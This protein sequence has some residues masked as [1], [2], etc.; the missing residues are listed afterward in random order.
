MKLSTPYVYC[1]SARSPNLS[2]HSSRRPRP[3]MLSRTLAVLLS[4]LSLTVA[5]RAQ[6]AV[7][8]GNQFITAH[9]YTDD[10]SGKFGITAGSAHNNTQF[11]FE[12]ITLVTSHVVFRVDQPPQPPRYYCNVPDPFGAGLPRPKV[13]GVGVTF[14]PYDHLD[15]SSDTIA[16]TWDNIYG[17]KVTMRFIPEKSTSIYDDGADMLL[18]FSYER[19]VY[20]Y[21]ELG[22][23][24]MLDTYNSAAS[25]FSGGGFG[26]QTSIVADGG[27]FEVDTPG[28][29][30]ID[31][32]GPIPTFYHVG[33]FLY[34]D[35]FTTIFPLHKLKG[36]TRGGAKL[37]PPDLFVI[38]DWKRLR[39]VSWDPPVAVGGEG[40][41]DCA[42]LLRWEKLVG[43]GTIRTSFGMNNK[44][45]NDMYTCRDNQL[46]VDIRTKRV[47]TQA[48]KNGP[49][50][51]EQFDVEMWIS[52][53]S[54]QFA[55]APQIR[56]D[57]PIVSIPDSTHR[58]TLDP[59]T[60]AIQY[61]Q[62][63]PRVT[64]KLVWRLSVNH[65]SADT[66]AILKFFHKVPF[67]DEKPFLDPC[68]PLV[69]VIG[70]HDPPPDPPK[71]TV[72]PSIERT[73]SGRNE[74]AFW[75]FRTTDRHL[76]FQY[77]SGLDT[78]TV[79]Q[80][81]NDNFELIVAP[82]PFTKCDTSVSV[83]ILAQV[84]DT[85]KAAHLV[86]SVTD[87]RGN[88]AF[89]S[90]T[91]RPRPDPFKPEVTVNALGTKGPPCNA[92]VYEVFA[93]D[94]INQYPDR[95]DHGMGTIEVIGTPINFYPIEINF[96]RGGLPI[97]K[98][99]RGASFRMRVI[100]TLL[101][102]SATVRVADFAGNDTLIT[103]NY[104][105][106]SD[107]AAPRARAIL[108]A[109][110]ESWDVMVSDTLPWDRGLLEVVEVSNLN[111]N[112]VFTPPVIA[113][114]APTA[115]LPTLYVRD[116]SLDA[117]IT[118][119][120]HDL[121]WKRNPVGHATQFTLKFSRIPDT[122][123]PNIIFTPDPL[124]VGSIG[125]VE[126]NDIHFINNVLYK[127]DVG[128]SQINVVAVSPN[129]RVR[130]QTPITFS[131]GAEKVN[132]QVEIIDTL[133]FNILDSIC[134]EAV[135]LAGNTSK[136]CYYYPVVPDIRSP[137]FLGQISAG[138]TEL[139]G[140]ASDDRLYDRGL[141]SISLENP[142]NLEPG[143]SVPN[144][145][146]TPT[147]SVSIA[148]TD[149]KKP[150]AGT[151]VV[152]DLVAD[153]DLTGEAQV[154][155]SLRMPFYLPAVSLGLRFPDQVEGGEPIDVRLVALDSF[156]AIEVGRIEFDA[157]YSGE[158]VYA[159]SDGAGLTVVDD[160]ATGM[161]VS[162]LTESGKLY[163]PGDTLGV[164]HF[165]TQKGTTVRKFRFDVTHG[166]ETVNSGVSKVIS[167]VQ[168]D[169]SAASFLKL[170]TIYCAVAYDSVTMINGECERVLTGEPGALKGARLAVLR[171][172]PQPVSTS[173]EPTVELDVRD[174][175]Y[176]G[177]TGT[178]MSS[179]GELLARF[180]CPKTTGNGIA[181]LTVQLPPTLS[182][183]LYFIRLSGS[184]GE[185]IVRVVVTE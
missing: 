67:E 149:P 119:E 62:L 133:T 1:L 22:I 148:V 144:L 157:R 101:D 153:R 159:G 127:Y 139:S 70:F 169:D 44:G 176:E 56:L 132:F 17:F 29:K 48:Q 150:I 60:P 35:D 75:T 158:A 165:T 39:D 11:L 58:L 107:T 104:C 7:S 43:S 154:V 134:L 118:L 140:T 3:A 138:R 117:Q 8:V 89:D 61:L 109:N 166:S 172:M 142:V 16:V 13:Q 147:T 99:D 179:A 126:I 52:N 135:D 88:V 55:I 45:V 95:G 155:H 91:Y 125:E 151:L 77:D 47:V 72:A 41:K 87:C 80:N 90:A 28:R 25:S 49:Y 174:L 5:A 54:T 94:T 84:I 33:N 53:T 50:D 14:K 143:F 181:H 23:V 162:L 74:T 175:P 171:V 71:D 184:T 93:G 116:N 97:R 170:P 123:A 137:L 59:S 63:A 106:L 82:F 69:T 173:K 167:V 180:E 113:P 183:G 182:S 9:V 10:R 130:P 121:E 51:P 98:F 37:T 131:P 100:D 164:L 112:I 30:F 78:I 81:D 27:Y 156:P 64:K 102:A 40:F 68:E 65:A 2:A 120:V 124:T 34:H 141:G 128:L 114:G 152:N 177:A 85:T 79:L 12:T 66:Q 21:A 168:P 163:M 36:T 57:T 108:L 4:M 122:L 76:W 146:G 96:D 185:D 92:P 42:T 111:N 15:Y 115:T 31:P 46:F 105:T 160:P 86:F 129:M 18:E 73:G 24:L 32:Y 19:T 26:D 178:L 38:D 161:H 110:R 103:L 136:K 145:K 83:S 6:G 20:S